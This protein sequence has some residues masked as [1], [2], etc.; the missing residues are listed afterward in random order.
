MRTLRL[1]I[2]TVALTAAGTGTASAA[3]AQWIATATTA[4]FVYTGAGTE[5]NRLEFAR[6]TFNGAPTLEVA[7]IGAAAAPPPGCMNHPSISS[8]IMC[9]L[10]PGQTLTRV[11][12]DAGAG[13]DI[14]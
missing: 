1:A 10:Q 4:E 7:Q 6:V 8:W 9:S 11:T 14:L 3:T 2:L 13:E 12:V 5:T